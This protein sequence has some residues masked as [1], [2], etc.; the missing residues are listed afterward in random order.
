ME[1]QSFSITLRGRF[2]AEIWKNVYKNA[3][4]ASRSAPESYA[5]ALKLHRFVDMGLQYM[6]TKWLSFITKT[7]V[8]RAKILTT[9]TK[10]SKMQLSQSL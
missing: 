2:R 10:N 5:K 4:S 6:C 1:F 8:S 3:V 7:L 9:Y